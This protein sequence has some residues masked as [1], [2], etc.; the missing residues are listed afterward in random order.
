MLPLAI[1]K[2]FALADFIGPEKMLADGLE[3]TRLSL[4]MWNMMIVIVFECVM[5]LAYTVFFDDNEGHEVVVSTTVAM[6][7]I[8]A[9]MIYS[10]QTYMSTWMGLNGTGM[11]IRL[12]VVVLISIGAIVGGRMGGHRTGYSK[13]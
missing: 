13:V 6:T 8:A 2:F 7:L 4:W 12:G 10:V 1:I 3:M 5:A 11:W 9:C